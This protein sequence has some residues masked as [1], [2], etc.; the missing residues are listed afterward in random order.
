VLLRVYENCNSV[1]TVRVW[2]IWQIV[3][4]DTKQT[5]SIRLISFILRCPR[6][7]STIGR[8][9]EV[10]VALLNVTKQMDKL[11]TSVSTN[12]NGQCDSAHSSE[13]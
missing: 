1:L 12:R 11:S 5:V 4:Y 8:P 7:N 9:I 13:E 2:N 6:A 3:F 10:S